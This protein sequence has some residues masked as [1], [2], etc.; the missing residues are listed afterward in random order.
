MKTLCKRMIV[1]ALIVPLMAC[2]DRPS[3]LLQ[4][5]ENAW[6][7]NEH[8]EAIRIFLQIVQR[9]PDSKQAETALLRVGETYM[10]NL[11]NPDKAVEYFSVVISKFPKGEQARAAHENLGNIFEYSKKDYDKAVIQYQYLIDTGEAGDADRY[12]FAIARCYYRKGD[13][14]QAILEYEMF[15]KRFPKSELIPEARYQTG[16]CYFVMNDCD[17]AIK[18]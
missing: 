2:I 11:S 6:Y 17:N 3:I 15:Q 18:Q 12:Q 14:Q 13:Y 10:L 1:T 9:Y 8:R 7:K 4:E 16:N 5:A